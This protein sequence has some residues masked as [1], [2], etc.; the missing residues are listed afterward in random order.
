MRGK[1]DLFDEKPS[2]PRRP[3][4]AST[5]H[6]QSEHLRLAASVLIESGV[7]VEDI[8]ALADLVQPERFKTVLRYYHERANRQPNA[9][10][11]C[12]AQTLIQVAQYH[13]GATAEE[14]A[15]LKRIASKLPPVPSDLTPKNKTLALQFESD[16]MRAKLLFFAEQLMAE[17][18][19]HLTQGRLHFVD[20]QIAI[21]ID[22]DLVI[23]LRPQNLV[24]LTWQRNFSE[25]DGPKGRLLLH[26]PA[27]KTKSKLQDLVAEIPPDAAKRLR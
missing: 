14:V 20:A 15:Q 27:R 23:P 22:V 8:K 1:P 3:L 10:V 2:A 11:V 26:I 6:Q 18:A 17:V 25:P 24:T 19:Q 13:S 16:R 9:F 12:L 7:P 21:A 4:A 5:L